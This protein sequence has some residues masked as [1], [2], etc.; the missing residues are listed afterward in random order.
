MKRWNFTLTPN[1][2]PMQ[3]ERGRGEGSLAA[4]SK[5]EV[6]HALTGSAAMAFRIAFANSGV[7]S[8]LACQRT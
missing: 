5:I 7:K 6:I 2:S 1:R 8:P 3:W 4:L